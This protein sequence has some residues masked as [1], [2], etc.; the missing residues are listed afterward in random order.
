MITVVSSCQVDYYLSN[1]IPHEVDWKLYI[2]CGYEEAYLLKNGP[3]KQEPN[4]N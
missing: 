3:K 4:L 1:A 2:C